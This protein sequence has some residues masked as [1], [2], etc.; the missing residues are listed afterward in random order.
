[1]PNMTGE[2]LS[3]KMMKIRPAIPVILCTGF[4]H[5]IAKE[6]AREIGIKAFA[7]KPLVRRQLA[8]TVRRVLDEKDLIQFNRSQSLS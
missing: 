8:E 5:I 2:Q 6:K 7:M 4:S 3:R 1:M